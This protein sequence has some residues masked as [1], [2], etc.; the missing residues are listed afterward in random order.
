MS[1]NSP[2]PLRKAVPW[3]L[4]AALIPAALSAWLHPRRPLWLNSAEVN[5]VSVMSVR[6]RADVV[7]IDARSEAAFSG[8]HIPGAISLPVD[9]W[10]GRVEA[11]VNAWKP[12]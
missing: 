3:L 2:Y 1:L 7:W 6:S 12:G 4:L 10:T 5:E 8:G 11:V 9:G